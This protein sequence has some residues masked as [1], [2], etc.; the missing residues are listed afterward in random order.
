[1]TGLLDLDTP[2]RY[3]DRPVGRRWF[4]GSLLGAAGAVALGRGLPTGYS[5][6]APTFSPGG[7]GSFA[8][9]VPGSSLYLLVAV[10]VAGSAIAH[11]CDGET[12]AV[13]F[14]GRADGGVLNLT[15]TGHRLVARV[16]P[17]RVE[18]VLTLDGAARPFGL[19]PTPADG[20]LFTARTAV[21]DTTYAASWV[22]LGRGRQRG[23][24]RVAA[25]A[26]HQAGRADPHRDLFG[27]GPAPTLVP[28]GVTAPG[29][30]RLD[31]VRLDQFTHKWGRLS[32]EP[33]AP[34]IAENTAVSPHSRR[35][36]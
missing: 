27:T 17:D 20:G 19:D 18:G 3:P 13:W 36:G 12:V 8:G 5:A 11:A 35:S 7:W 22:V 1:M 2:A 14:A 30:V 4:L 34:T 10:D 29:G 26:T 32:R 21:A 23:V 15:G 25:A 16:G 31:P 9:A 24:L 28:S 6:L 33:F